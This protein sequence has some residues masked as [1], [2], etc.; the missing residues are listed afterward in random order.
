MN[1]RLIYEQYY[2]KENSLFTTKTEIEYKQRGEKRIQKRNRKG[3][4]S[5]YKVTNEAERSA[6]LSHRITRQTN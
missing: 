3:T 5:S 2:N 6:E 1:G 4:Q